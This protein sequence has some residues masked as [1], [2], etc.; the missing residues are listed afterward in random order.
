MKHKHTYYF[1]LHCDKRT[2]Y[3]IIDLLK[4]HLKG[5]KIACHRY[6]FGRWVEKDSGHTVGFQ[7]K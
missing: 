5:C 4:I 3:F 2:V 1:T 6:L 7:K